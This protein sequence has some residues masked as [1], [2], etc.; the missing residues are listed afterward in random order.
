[1]KKEYYSPSQVREILGVRQQTVYM[2][3]ESHLIPAFK[4][5]SRWKIPIDLF[6]EWRK[7]QAVTHG[8]I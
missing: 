1:M 7:E 3:L 5:G 8:K 6:D 2:M 4:I